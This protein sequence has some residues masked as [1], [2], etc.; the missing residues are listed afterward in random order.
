[1]DFFHV[2]NRGVEKR[3]IAMDDKDRARFMHGLYVF[4]DQNTSLHPH[5]SDRKNE[6]TKRKLLVHIHAFVLMPNHYHLLLS[7]LTDGGIALF[8]QK[9]NMGYT[10]YFNA[11]HQ[12]SGALW[13]GKHKKI[14]IER[15]AHFIYIPFYIHLNPLDLCM[16]EW[17]DGKVQSSRK[18][19]EYLRIYRWSSH[20]DYLGIKNFPSLTYR[21]EILSD[22]KKAHEY[23][24]EIVSILRDSERTKHSMLL[25]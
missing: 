15:D 1:M 17:R 24:N 16:P 4:N 22:F 21:E 20:V 13:Q 25:E 3:K 8:M 18:A 7:E 10:K 14:L 23:E 6:R 11:R 9:L 5:Q 12:R 19:L 2:I